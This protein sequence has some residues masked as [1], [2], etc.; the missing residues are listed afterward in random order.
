MP[1]PVKG[2]VLVK[3]REFPMSLR[4]VE[5]EDLIAGA[6]GF[7]KIAEPVV[8]GGGGAVTKDFKAIVAEFSAG[9][10]KSPRPA[11]RFRQLASAHIMHRQGI[12]DRQIGSVCASTLV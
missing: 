9:L 8:A 10:G 5:L 7:G 2:S 6:A 1:S 11:Q 12:E 3:C 4:I